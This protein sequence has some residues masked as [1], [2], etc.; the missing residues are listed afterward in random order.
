M[1]RLGVLAGLLLGLPLISGA[2]GASL[3]LKPCRLEHP[4][5]MLAVPAECGNLTVPENYAAPAGRQIELF[6]ARVP[7]ISLNNKAPD[8]LF[9]IAGGPGTSAVDLY[10]SSATPFDRVRRDSDIVLVDQRGTGRSHRLDCKN[11]DLND[12]DR[13]NEVEVGPESVKCRDEL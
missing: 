11:E 12:F 4:A 9:L 7:A 8:P 1:M 3:V 5:R 2:A 10:T 6:V 13:F